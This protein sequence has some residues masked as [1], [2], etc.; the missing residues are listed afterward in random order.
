MEVLL[1]DDHPTVNIGIATILESTGVF[2]AC[3]QAGTL[4]QAMELIEK[5]E[6]L[7]ALVILDLILGD[8]NGLDFLPML[9][10]HCADKKAPKPPVLVCSAVADSFTIQTAL[11]SGAA[12]YLSKAGGRA[13]LL[14]AIYAI[15]GGNV[16]V[17]DDLNVKLTEESKRLYARFTKQEIKVIDLMNA[18]KTNREIADELCISI[19][20]V[21]NY[22]SKIYF[23]TGLSS[24]EEVRR[25]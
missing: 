12:G 16:Y 14:K 17:S 7:P 10:K 11:K 25:L 20:T 22:T 24:R 19:R 18:N 1:I 21:E 4:A 23:K 6:T 5:S 2:T 15:L 13:E 9:E 3:G 8:E